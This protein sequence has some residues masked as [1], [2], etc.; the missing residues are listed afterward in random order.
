MTPLVT[1]PKACL[2]RKHA[3]FRQVRPSEP[4]P[5]GNLQAG[6]DALAQTLSDRK[7]GPG[8]PHPSA[9]MMV[10]AIIKSMHGSK[11][12]GAWNQNQNLLNVSSEFGA[13]FRPLP[14]QSR[15][16]SGG[17]ES[18][19]T[20]QPQPQPQQSCIPAEVHRRLPSTRPRFPEIPRPRL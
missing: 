19:K 5:Q 11:Q 2:V 8:V 18:A 20:A 10:T 7:K 15:S 13:V 1:D 12:L 6:S 14:N 9:D 16:G 4:R 17:P 3:D